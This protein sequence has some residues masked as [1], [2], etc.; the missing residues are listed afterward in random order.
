MSI[1]NNE[2]NLNFNSLTLIVMNIICIILVLLIKV[3]LK[4]KCGEKLLLNY[5]FIFLFSGVI[6]SLID[7]IFW[8]GSLDYILI[9]KKIIDVK[10]IYLFLGVI[11]LLLLA[12][13]EEMN[14]NKK[15]GVIEC[16]ITA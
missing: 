16:V 15:K 4:N 3:Y 14:D 8:G 1:F 7:K 2:M 6:C 9:Y 5:C 11:L 12:I 10:D 13:Q